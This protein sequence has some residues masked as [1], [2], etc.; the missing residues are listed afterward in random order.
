MSCHKTVTALDMSPAFTDV[1][2]TVEVWASIAA[3]GAAS[4]RTQP[5]VITVLAA[6]TRLSALSI[7]TS[8]SPSRNADTQRASVTGTGGAHSCRVA[9]S[10]PRSVDRIHVLKPLRPL[11]HGGGDCQEVVM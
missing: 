1:V 5:S 9:A 6:A 3:V 4:P 7:S 10:R 2:F 8:S 11:S